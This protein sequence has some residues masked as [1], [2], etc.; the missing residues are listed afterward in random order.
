[1]VLNFSALP[2]I[3]NVRLEPNRVEHFTMGRLSN[4][5]RKS[6]P[7]TNALAYLPG[8]SVSRITF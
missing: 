5:V 3:L 7:W 8:A 2:N 1:M 6:F 4:L